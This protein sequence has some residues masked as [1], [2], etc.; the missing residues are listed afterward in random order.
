MSAMAR[1]RGFTLLEM[2]L[3]VFI[4]AALAATTS[5]VIDDA[6]DQARVDDTR[7]RLDLIRTAISGTDDVRAP[8]TGFVADM[9]RLP[10]SIR[11]LL[12]D[13]SVPPTPYR[14][15]P[16]G[17]G[18][19]WRGPYLRTLPGS[20]GR[21]EFWDG[22]GNLNT[23]LP[24][25]DQRGDPNFGWIIESHPDPSPHPFDALPHLALSGVRDMRITSRGADGQFSIED[26][27]NSIKLAQAEHHV[28]LSSR[29]LLVDLFITNSDTPAADD[30]R[31]THDLVI[32][33]LHPDGA[34][35]FTGVCVSQPE[36]VDF[37]VD[38]PDP[39]LN[40]RSRQIT[41]R[42]SAG[43]DPIP[44]GVR[45]IELCRWEVVPPSADRE[46]VSF[47]SRS[48]ALLELRAQASLPVALP[49]RLTVKLP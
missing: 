15:D 35:G 16:T 23:E 10:V 27:Q 4:L 25:V 43:L 8:I 29:T 3:V 37:D 12:E 7:N 21:P 6:H 17:V 49:Q 45:A 44:H 13:V 33:V 34:G 11:E 39:A 41:F 24:L 1:Q 19:G 47:A 20:S 42:F 5:S 40:E 30:P 46:A 31:L 48:S 18:S 2:L 38:A 14:V 28:D 26:A 36:T 9:G 22:F 32:R